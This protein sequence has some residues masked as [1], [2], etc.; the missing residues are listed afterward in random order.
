YGL[1]RYLN[2]DTAAAL[3]ADPEPPLLFNYLGR[4]AVGG[5]HEAWSVAPETGA[6]PPGVDPGMPVRHPLELNALTRDGAE[7]PVLAATWTW[8]RRLLAEQDVRALA[9]AWF[10]Q[11]GG[12][13]AHSG[14][15]GAGGH[16]PSDMSLPDLDQDEL[17][18]F[19]AEWR[20]T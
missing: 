1:L 12:L 5:E 9:D 17:D 18:E 7:G 20:L 16:T 2:P 10:A 15:P 14:S 8:P 4:V 6:L 19:E 11:L 13:V 3:A